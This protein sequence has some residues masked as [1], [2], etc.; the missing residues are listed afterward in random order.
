MGHDVRCWL[1][2]TVHGLA[3][4]F[5]AA[6]DP[7]IYTTDNVSALARLIEDEVED[8]IAYLRPEEEKR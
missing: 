8:F 4:T 2:Q 3:D 7:S 5:M 6:E 1:S